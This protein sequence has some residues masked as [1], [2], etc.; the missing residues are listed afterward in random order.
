VQHFLSLLV[1]EDN[2]AA[3]TS[4]IS[5]MGKK[6]VKTASASKRENDFQ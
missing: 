2:V 4:Q 6:P 5:R 3:F 1:M